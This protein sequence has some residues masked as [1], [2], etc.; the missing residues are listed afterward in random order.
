MICDLKPTSED[1]YLSVHKAERTSWEWV[2]H[3]YSEMCAKEVLQDDCTEQCKLS[4]ACTNDKKVGK[5]TCTV[6]CSCNCGHLSTYRSDVFQHAYKWFVKNI[7]LHRPKRSI[8]THYALRRKRGGGSRGG[9]L[10]LHIWRNLTL[11][12]WCCMKKI[13]LKIALAP[14]PS[15]PKYLPPPL[16]SLHVS[17]CCS[18]E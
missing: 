2:I 7:T 13:G 11:A 6:Q 10:S 5:S 3:T 15:I 8:L 9:R 1:T 16:T 4:L 14:P 17:W 18:C 12:L